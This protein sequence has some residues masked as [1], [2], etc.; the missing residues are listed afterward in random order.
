M[1][2]LSSTWP[3]LRQLLLAAAVQRLCTPPSQS[4]VSPDSTLPDSNQVAAN[5]HTSAA[6]GRTDTLAQWAGWLLSV[7]KE[8]GQ[9]KGKQQ[10]VGAKR[11]S[12]Q[13]HSDVGVQREQWRPSSAQLS[14]LLADCLHA[15]AQTPSMH[16]DPVIH[17][18][19]AALRRVAGM[20]LERIKSSQEGSAAQTKQLQ[21]LVELSQVGAG[22]ANVGRSS[23]AQK[24]SEALAAAAAARDELMQRSREA[25]FTAETTS[26]KC[27]PMLH[28]AL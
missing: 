28:P 12:S 5:T 22:E 2:G 16:G 8:A 14:S 11:K 18:G 20:L 6:T 27:A 26:A 7:A 25:A 3:Q 19:E 4:G 13:P 24:I 1:Q 23:G 21:Q 9:K 17:S 10:K 15:L